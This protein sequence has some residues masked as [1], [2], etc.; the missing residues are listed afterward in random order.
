MSVSWLLRLQ[1]LCE[2]SKAVIAEAVRRCAA[3]PLTVAVGATAYRGVPH[4]LAPQGWLADAA[5][6]TV[7]AVR[8]KSR[9][10]SVLS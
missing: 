2:D 5:M 9:L 7:G 8:L 3:K 6:V 1:N 10:Q 4:A